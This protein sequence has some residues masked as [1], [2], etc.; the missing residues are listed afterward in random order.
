MTTL[1][2][3]ART[4]KPLSFVRG[5]LPSRPVYHD[6]VSQTDRAWWAAQQAA[7]QQQ[8]EPDWD[9]LALEAEQLDRACWGPVL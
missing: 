3:S 6:P 8:H 5:V 9:Q 1:F 2:D 4:R 7:Q